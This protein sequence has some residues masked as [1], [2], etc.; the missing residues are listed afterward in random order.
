METEAS[1]R[2][3]ESEAKE[4]VE[5]AVWAEAERDATRHEA[6]MARLDAETAGSARAQV[7]YEFAMVQ[8]PLASSKDAR[9]KGESELTGVPARLSYFRRG[10]AEGGG[11]G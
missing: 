7:E 4:A 1:S 9:Q 2:C 11:R 8:H 6:S 3:W 10:L 5:K